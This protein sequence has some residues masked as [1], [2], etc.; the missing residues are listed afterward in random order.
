MRKGKRQ[1]NKPPL[2]TENESYGETERGDSQVPTCLSKLQSWTQGRVSPRDFQLEGT[3]R[4]QPKLWK[5]VQC[6]KESMFGIA[7]FYVED[8]EAVR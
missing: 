5:Q 7:I 4:I 1:V 6:V 8:K 2:G 3:R